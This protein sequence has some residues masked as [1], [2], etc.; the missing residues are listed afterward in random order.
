MYGV[1]LLYMAK[2]MQAAELTPNFAWGCEDVEK[3]GCEGWVVVMGSLGNTT[4][5]SQAD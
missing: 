2:L 1:E 3:L 5:G 4:W